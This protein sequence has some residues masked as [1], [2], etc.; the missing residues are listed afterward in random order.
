MSFTGSV[1]AFLRGTFDV[2]GRACRSE[3]WYAMLFGVLA[4]LLAAFVDSLTQRSLASPALNLAFLV[5]GL[6]LQVR[7]L[8]D[9]GRTGRWALAPVGAFLL[10]A[11]LGMVPDL[12]LGIGDPD[13]GAADL[14]LFVALMAGSGLL[15]AAAAT[16]LLVWDCLPGSAGPNRYGPPRS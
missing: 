5:P 13:R 3:F 4:G 8:H 2:S 15:L 14:N 12:D 9:F 6:S 7:R 11:A 10:L 16:L 1:E